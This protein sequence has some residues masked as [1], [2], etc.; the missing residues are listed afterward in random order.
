MCTTTKYYRHII[1]IHVDYS[2]YT[3]AF[4]R[5]GWFPL[6]TYYR[7]LPLI[8]LRMKKIVTNFFLINI[9]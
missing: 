5:A 1:V 6:L 3:R 7:V 9:K 2:V 4:I 8:Y